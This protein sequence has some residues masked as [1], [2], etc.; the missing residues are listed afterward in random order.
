MNLTQA[1]DRRNYTIS[2]RLS[3]KH[4]NTALWYNAAVNALTALIRQAPAGAVPVLQSLADAQ[5]QHRLFP[6]H[7]GTTVPVVVGVSGGADSV[8]LVHA[9]RQVV[10]IWGLTLHV[11]HLDH[12]LRPDSAQDA[13]W[14]A[15]FARRLGLPLHSMRLSADQLA[16]HPGGLE[17]AA[18][19]A[20]YA[21]LHD[22]ACAVGTTGNPAL[23]AVAHH[24]EDQAET[25]LMNFLRGSGPAGLA[26]MAWDAPLPH[27][28]EMPVR[29][30][31]PL[32]GVRRAAILA[33]CAAYDLT[34][35]VDASNQDTGLLRNRIRHILLPQ[36]A[37]INPSIVATLGR[38]A[39]LFAAEAARSQRIDEEALQQTRLDAA[40]PSPDRMVLDADRLAAL[41]LATRRGVIRLAL[42]ALGLDLRDV[43]LDTIDRLIDAAIT[44]PYSSG[45][46]PLAGE[47][48]WTL[49]G[50]AP[51]RLCLH[52][53]AALP[54]QPDHPFLASPADRQPRP[55]PLEGTIATGA[56]RLTSSLIPVLSLPPGWRSSDTPW[57]AVMDAEESAQ[58]TLAAAQ[59]GMKIAPL[60]MAGK[61][62]SVGDLLTD[63][64]VPVAI[65][66]GWPVVL[67]GAGRVVWA[68]GLALSHH[69]RIRSQTE[70]A[71]I[72]TW[73]RENEWATD[74]SSHPTAMHPHP[75]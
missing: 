28:A 3:K 54:V 58:L 43:G 5:D 48:A 11:A 65:R 14:V 26:G 50:G 6:A 67:D 75:V 16:G 61:Q 1:A 45:P 17:A 59:P 36:L 23:V 15:A 9:L 20:R 46:H 30:V 18:R 37:E 29:L 49:I 63:H 33:Y 7:A 24:Q 70:R 25:V 72:L 10:P 35:R 39:D 32:L 2:D 42:A 8:C 31:R 13:A 47:I 27:V 71:R 21:F 68:C 66:S 69:A 19:A 74:N 41:D 62:R 12:A 4:P 56:W 44:T 64:K 52:R 57:R 73:Q 60:G 53:T 40:A 51:R 38:T 34:W 22:T 55:I